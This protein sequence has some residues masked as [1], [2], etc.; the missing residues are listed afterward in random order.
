MLYT[1]LQLGRKEEREMWGLQ[2]ST[3]CVVDPVI[4]GDLPVDAL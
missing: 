1:S 3:T 2:L 4:P